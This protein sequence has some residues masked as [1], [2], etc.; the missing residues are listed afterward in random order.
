MELF[1]AAK[2]DALNQQRSVIVSKK[3]SI[4]KMIESDLKC[5]LF[6]FSKNRKKDLVLFFENVVK[7]V[8][9]YQVVL[10]YQV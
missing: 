1:G 8:P 10:R 4:W 5:F 7:Q 9:M 6:S 2:K 3:M